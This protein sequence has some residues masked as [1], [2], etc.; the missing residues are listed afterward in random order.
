MAAGHQQIKVALLGVNLGDAQLLHRVH[1]QEDPLFLTEIADGLHVAGPAV[2]PLQG[3]HDDDAGPLIGQGGEVVHRE[4]VVLGLAYPDFDLLLPAHHTPGQGH[5]DEL[6]I[7]GDDVVA[8]GQ[9]DAA[10]GDVQAM[11]GAL[12]QGDLLRVG[13][14]QLGGFV[15]CLA[16]QGVH[17][18]VVGAGVLL[19]LGGGHVGKG[20]HRPHRA[21][22]GEADAGRVEK[23][24]L[25]QNGPLLLADRFKIDGH[26][27]YLL[28][29]CG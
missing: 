23:D 3:G 24:H 2:A 9:L 13:V 17:G 15:V 11:G 20:L 16:A 22:G 18:D 14:E 4:A 25:L 28:Y 12:H 5:L 21:L 19:L 6:Q 1:H 10:G 26:K 7:G 29:F 27:Y 8:V